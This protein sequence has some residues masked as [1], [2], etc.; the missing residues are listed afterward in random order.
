MTCWNNALTLF[1]LMLSTLWSRF[2]FYFRVICF[3][4]PEDVV[5][6]VGYPDAS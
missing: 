2:P 4:F 1:V 6:W 5:L 3:G